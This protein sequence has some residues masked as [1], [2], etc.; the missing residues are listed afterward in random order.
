MT[1]IYVKT[2]Q[3]ICSFFVKIKQKLKNVVSLYDF[4]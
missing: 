1:V 2:F 4:K 3:A